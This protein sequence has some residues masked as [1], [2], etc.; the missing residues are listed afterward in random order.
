MFRI[1]RWLGAISMLALAAPLA[2]G[3]ETRTTTFSIQEPFGL[4]WG[5]DRVNYVVEFPEGES[6]PDGLCLKDGS[7]QPVACQ[8]S[9]IELWP[10]KTLKKAK[11]SFLATL[12]AGENSSWSLTPGKAAVLQPKT[13]LTIEQKAATD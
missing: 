5:P 1:S 8:F 9:D 12:K 2:F 3:A 13:D 6:T 11:L 4:S 7:G 10:D